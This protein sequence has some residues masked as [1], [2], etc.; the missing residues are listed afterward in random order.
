V[1]AICGIETEHCSA[2][3]PKI[4]YISP[5]CIQV[6]ETEESARAKN[7]SFD[8]VSVPM[9]YS[10]RYVATK[11]KLSSEG[12]IKL[13][14]DQSHRII[15]ASM[16]SCYASEIAMTLN[17]FITSN[18]TCD[19]I[20]KYIFAHPTEGEIIRKC[21]LLYKQRGLSNDIFI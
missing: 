16:I 15:G 6:G 10:G 1:N 5:E 2:I 21:I 8:T 11:G 3:V 4:I 9:N 13:L 12:K 17:L 7:L 20:L 19:E 14:I 18:A